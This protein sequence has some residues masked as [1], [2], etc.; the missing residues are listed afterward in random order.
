MC[1]VNSCAIDL[2]FLNLDLAPSVFCQFFIQISGETIS[3][4]IK[5]LSVKT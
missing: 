2:S 3:G 4:I 1:A 5:A